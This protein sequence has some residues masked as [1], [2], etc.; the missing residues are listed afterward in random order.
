[1]F[2]NSLNIRKL[3]ISITWL[4]FFMSIN[5][6]PMEFE[7]PRLANACANQMLGSIFSIRLGKMF[8]LVALGVAS[9]FCVRRMLCPRADQRRR[10]KS[11]YCIL[12]IGPRPKS[13]YDDPRRM[14]DSVLAKSMLGGLPNGSGR[15]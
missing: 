7:A 10:S 12:A 5:L 3:L 14:V 9:R 13:T 6:N 15:P 4:S 11:L 8:H 1:M 2:I